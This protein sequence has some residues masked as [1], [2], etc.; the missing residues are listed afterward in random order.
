VI[1]TRSS[2]RRIL[3]LAVVVFAVT[4]GAVGARH[5]APARFLVLDTV[6]GLTFVI[7][8]LIAWERRP[9]VRSGP[10]LILSGALWFVGSWAPMGTVPASTLGFAFE[11]YYDV[12]L[13][14]LVL[15]FPDVPLAGRHRTVLVVMAGAFVVRSASRLLIGCAC[16]PNP[17][18]V[19]EDPILFERSQL[20]TSIVIAIAA[21][22]VAAFAAARPRNAGPAARRILRP[23]AIAGVVAALVAA[24]DALD[25]IVF[26]V[27]GEGLLRFPEPWGEIASWTIIAA[28]SLVP[29]G[30]LLGVVR[31]R[32]SHGRL[33]PLVLELDRSLDPGRLQ[34]A[35]RHALGDPSLRLLLWDRDA[36][37]WLDANG[38]SAT[39]PEE[40]DSVAVTTLDR[41]G[42]PIAAIAH[43]RVLREDPGLVA[44]ATAVLRLAVEN[45]R[46]T[47]EVREQL[48]SVR[49]SRARLVEAAESERRRIERDLH[50]GAQ[51][52]LIGVALSLQEAR[53]EARRHSPDASFVRRLDD[54]AD[55][56]LAAIEEL[57]ELARGI[58][59]AVLT[60][61]GLG[62]A[63]TSLARRAAV[64][65]ELDLSLDGRLPTTI[66]ATAYYVVAE[67]LTNVT[68]HARASSVTVR[69]VHRDAL[70]EVEVGDDGDGGADV[71]LGSGIRGL[72][73]RLEAVSGSLELHSPP[74]GGTRLRAVIPCG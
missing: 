48:A 71:R 59:P 42:E 28:I 4:T 49:A 3:A 37:S 5:G 8:G 74:G 69:V 43:D 26:I 58:H 9:E 22:S 7:A 36:A 51:Q 52:R 31:L 34:L 40:T 64:P 33:A 19:V 38:E 63:V 27:T 6:F 16:M 1:A 44:A 18:A 20:V 39:R 23:V 21:L 13:A 15:T 45:E 57:R 72:V 11:R 14:Y 65:V 30:F 50:D 61:D 67:G 25:L 41:D 24:W 47:A 29:L 46:L 70:L 17:F 56:L 53:G 32:I 35:L 2:A 66:E 62:V 10:L 60:E 73:D 54:T 68:R 12:V 55:E